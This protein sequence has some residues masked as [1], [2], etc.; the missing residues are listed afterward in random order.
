MACCPTE[1]KYG[2]EDCRFEKDVDENFHCSICYNVLKE[3]R[4]CRNNDHIFCLACITRHLKV[5]SQTCPECNEHLSV[6]TLRRP[7]V[8]NNIL[9]KLKINCDHASRGCPQFTCL[10]DLKTHVV[11][12]GYAPVLC[13]NAECGMEINK[14]DKVHHETKV[15][16]YR[17]VKCHDCGQIQEDVGTLKGSLRELDGKV[18]QGIKTLDGKVEAAVKQINGKVEAAVKEMNGKV[19]AAVKEINKEMNEKVEAAV[20]EMNGKVEASSGQT[21]KEIGEVKKEVKDMKD[22][23]SK[24]NKDVDEVKVMMIQMLEKLNMLELP[25]QLPSPTEGMLNIPRQ[26]I[27]IAG[28]Y[29]GHSTSGKS[30]EIYSWEKNGWFEVSP[31]NDIHK[32]ASSFIYKDQL[33]VVGGGGSKAIE[34]LNL[35]ELPL[36][37]TKFLGELPYKC[38]DHQIV[39]YQQSVIHIGGYNHGKGW[40]NVVSELQLTSPC[41]MKELCQM[42]QPRGCHGAEVFEDKVLILGGFCP[43]NKTTDSVLEFDPKRNECKEMPKLPSA[44]KRMATVRWRDE[45]VVLGGTDKGGQILNDVFMYDSKTGK[46]TAL[47]SMLEKRYGCCAVITGNTIVVMGGENEKRQCLSS[48]ECFTM[49]GSTWEYLSAMNNARS[50]AV[51][52]VLPST[53][54]YV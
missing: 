22:N 16:D 42:L 41:I 19:E 12:C 13:S 51:A 34:T 31:M 44:L 35:N 23:L 52:E 2:Y 10:E 24:V 33:F 11:N 37:W 27:L 39:V 48:V 14:Q 5:N 53:R 45:V 15:C 38:D 20:K 4:T 21:K 7:R 47:P 3:P 28:G 26:D 30:T 6:D 29:G 32:G 43:G 54:K 9:S 18:E 50:R 1:E 25:N 17:K 49:G 40:S 8:L 46:T 36:K